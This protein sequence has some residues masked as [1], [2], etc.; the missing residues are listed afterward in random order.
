MAEYHL[1]ADIIQ[2][3]AGRSIVACAAYRAAE[4]LY[5]ERV[6][7]TWNFGR[8][9]GVEHKEILAPRGAP[10]WVSD[11]ERLWNVIER[12]E[13]R[14]DS[15]LGRQFEI[16]LPVELSSEAQVELARAFCD[17][18]FVSR[19]LV[20]DLAIHRDN[21]ENPHMHVLVTMRPL[22][23]DRF[24]RR[25]IREWGDRELML[26][27][28][29][30]AWALSANRSLANEG[31]RE[32]IDHRS[33]AARGIALES[34]PKAFR[35][36][37]DAR[38][39]GRGMVADRLSHRLT[40]QRRN[41]ARIVEDPTIPLRA[42]TSQ[43]A[44]FTERDLQ[45]FL[46]R[47]TADAQQFAFA[48]ARVKDCSAL[49]TLPAKEGEPQRYSTT[50]VI[51]EEERVLVGAQALAQRERHRVRRA[52]VEQAV[53]FVG[54]QL[55]EEQLAGLRHLARGSD[56]VVLEGVAGA[57]KTR[58]LDAFRIACEAAG[59]RVLGA[60]LAGKA[61]DGL[62][63]D[64]H[65]AASTLHSWQWRWREG[66][67]RLTSRDVFVLDEA[68]MVGT[69]QFGALLDEIEHAGA[70]LVLVG[71]TRQLQ[72]IDR[73]AP[74][75][76]LQRRY[77][78]ASLRKV[79]R[80][81]DHG[82]QRDATVAFGTGRP[83]DALRA[84]VEQRRTHGA[85]DTEQARAAL[86]G[87]WAEDTL[88][89]PV[90]QTLLLAFRRRDV[91]ELNQLAR[92]VRRERGE[93]GPDQLVRTR[94]GARAFA[95]HDRV[96][97]LKND[98]RLGVKN[99]T[100]GTIRRIDGSRLVV[101]LDDKRVV[102]FDTQRYQA[103]DHG[104]AGT[105]HKSQGATVGRTYVLAS[106]YMDAA[107]TYVALSRHRRDAHLFY[108]A[109]EFRGPEQLVERLSRVREEL[110]A[111]ELLGYEDMAA[112]DERRQ[113]KTSARLRHDRVRPAE[114]HAQIELLR[115]ASLKPR[116]SAA[117]LLEELPEVRARTSQ[118]TR[119]A[120]ALAAAEQDLERFRNAHPVVM[121][122]R[123]QPAR[124]CLARVDDARR[125]LQHA[126]EA[127]H[128]VRTDSLLLARAERL[129]ARHNAPIHRALADWRALVL[130]QQHRTRTVDAVLTRVLEH[131]RNAH[132]TAWRV[133]TEQDASRTFEPLP[134]PD[135]LKREGLV[136]LRDP[137]G[138]PDVLATAA[139]CRA[140]LARDAVRLTVASRDLLLTSQPD[141][142]LNR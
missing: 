23:G 136:L 96:F 30:E 91:Q 18:H 56:L 69:A 83:E 17:E 52:F 19:G 42:L 135:H 127:L 102:R 81:E 62:Q 65:I 101:E 13:R 114:V 92:A 31:H 132:R 70:K 112:L 71:D 133:P 49:V 54:T 33:Y 84:Y 139:Q 24:S 2:R 67:D 68:A 140:R 20:C 107:A 87:R 6:A 138:G 28:W 88:H 75:R 141:R 60:A 76:V 61:A 121:T 14:W 98:T 47:H 90:D 77:G 118:R 32:R 41:G 106:R 59:Y 5:D 63:A 21:P 9:G 137:A 10:A 134:L 125:A 38:R 115:L 108:S 34:Q 78:A 22:E 120:R 126:D 89:T 51:A 57:G 85:P 93:L 128:S 4:K 40:V 142:S 104:Y 44:T 8:K 117:E 74:M 26:A 12:A 123:T 45:R 129:A 86:V 27:H 37:S 25:K 64:A 66:R 11:R 39:D 94:N 95:K 109:R 58:A 46:N 111:H 55:D 3:S 43:R 29:R 97:F 16:A 7:L 35:S 48:L 53:R 116:R 1:Y 82:W 103:L 124:E 50:E 131:N 15:Q 122:L 130:A 72:S 80:Q 100:L 99:G 119:A 105:I 73:G 110:M 113:Q 36:P 79:R